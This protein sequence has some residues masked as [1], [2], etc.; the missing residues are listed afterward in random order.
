M[1]RYT[2]EDVRKLVAG[3][4]RANKMKGEIPLVLGLLT[5]HFE[6]EIKRGFALQ[7][8]HIFEAFTVEL[9]EL[10]GCK[11]NLVFK[12][13]SLSDSDVIYRL[14]SDSAVAPYT[15]EL[16]STSLLPLDFVKLI[17]DKLPLIMEEAI[18]RFPDISDKIQQLIDFADY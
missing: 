14:K 9:G 11:Y 4:K 5:K 18:K 17:H 10:R 6:T 7:K 16:L 3:S 1:S 2:Q 8:S 12:L 15:G 13:M